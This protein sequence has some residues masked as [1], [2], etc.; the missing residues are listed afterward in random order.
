VIYSL[1]NRDSFSDSGSA[2]VE[3][4]VNV[5]LC[6][7]SILLIMLSA[8]LKLSLILSLIPFIFFMNLYISRRFVKVFYEEKGLIYAA[9]AF[10]YFSTLYALAVGTGTV[11]GVVNYFFKYKGTF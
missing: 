9:L 7:L 8:A 1:K 3:L 6:C 5:A 11:I 4:K 10:L 2:S